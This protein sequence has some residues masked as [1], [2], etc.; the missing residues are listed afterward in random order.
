MKGVQLAQRARRRCAGRREV[1]AE[2]RRFDPAVRERDPNLS[3]C[4]FV[5]LLAPTCNVRA[6]PKR[7]ACDRDGYMYVCIQLCTL[8][9]LPRLADRASYFCNQPPRRLD[10]RGCVLRG[11]SNVAGGSS[12][13][14]RCARA[15]DLCAKLLCR[16]SAAD[17]LLRLRRPSGISFSSAFSSSS[18]GRC[19]FRPRRLPQNVK[20]HDLVFLWM[21]RICIRTQ[22]SVSS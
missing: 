19:F 8:C 3:R 6:L 11:R 1:P 13:R 22:T 10:R 5:A 16:S 2:L 17:R 12:S 7:S 4:S 9:G 21:R 20:S 14:M 15:R 18:L